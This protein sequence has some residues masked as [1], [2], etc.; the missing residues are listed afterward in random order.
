MFPR[1]TKAMIA[2]NLLV[3]YM[4]KQKSTKTDTELTTKDESQCG[5]TH[6]HTA[7]FVM[8]ISRSG[9][10][11]EYQHGTFGDSGKS[12]K[13][14]FFRFPEMTEK[15]TTWWLTVSERTSSNKAPTSGTANSTPS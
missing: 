5:E 1:G 11:K 3:T 14:E 9:R 6:G 7:T 15:M 8:W 13:L 10:Q 12:P 4:S 2:Q